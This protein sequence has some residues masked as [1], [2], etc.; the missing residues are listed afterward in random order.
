[1]LDFDHMFCNVHGFEPH[2]CTGEIN[3]YHV[4]AFSVYL[5]IQLKLALTFGGWDPPHRTV[6]Q[7]MGLCPSLI[8]CG[9]RLHRDTRIDND[10]RRTKHKYSTHMDITYPL[11]LTTHLNGSI[12]GRRTPCRADYDKQQK[13][14]VITWTRVQQVLTKVLYKKWINYLHS[15]LIVST[16]ETK[17]ERLP[18]NTTIGTSGFMGEI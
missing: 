8:G 17:H 15:Y 11:Q 12:H 9:R 2:P 10:N 3:I 16:A 7:N 18:E 6:T 1:M 14:P 5:S 4:L 13:S